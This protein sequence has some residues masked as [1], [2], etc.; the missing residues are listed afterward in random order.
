VNFSSN[1]D[2]GRKIVVKSDDRRLV[3]GEVYSPLHVDTDTEAMTAAEIEAMAHRFLIS[4]RTDKIDVGH[5]GMESG[6]Q[7]CESYIAK[8]NDADGFVEGA[9]VLGVYVLPDDLWQAVK[10]GELN[11]FSFAG[12]VGR[13]PA[14]AVVEVTRKLEGET[15]KSIEDALTNLEK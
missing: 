1:G 11:G 4:G 14:E 5:N 10:S 3:F 6:C 2:L 9:W 7:V 13:V 15:E 8:A 12:A